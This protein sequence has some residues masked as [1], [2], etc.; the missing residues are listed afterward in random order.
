MYIKIVLYGIGTF[1]YEVV[2]KYEVTDI[3]D[4]ITD[5]A[6][7]NLFEGRGRATGR[8]KKFYFNW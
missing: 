6:Y 2:L 5:Q 4:S 3:T 1:K 7:S 8:E